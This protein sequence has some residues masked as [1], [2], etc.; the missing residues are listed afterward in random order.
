MKMED[1]MKIR[2]NNNRERKKA[3]WYFFIDFLILLPIDSFYIS[4]NKIAH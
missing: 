3:A 1:S 2:S 4:R